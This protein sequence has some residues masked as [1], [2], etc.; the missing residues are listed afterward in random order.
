MSNVCYVFINVILWGIGV[1]Y[2]PMAWEGAQLEL[3]ASYFIFILEIP[4]PGKTV[5]ILGQFDLLFL[6][7]FLIV[8]TQTFQTWESTP[9]KKKSPQISIKMKFSPGILIYNS[10]AS[11]TGN[12][13][14][15]AGIESLPEPMLTRSMAWYGITG[16]LWGNQC[17]L[18]HHSSTLKVIHTCRNVTHWGQDKMADIFPSAFSNAFSW[19]NMQKLQF[20][21]H[22]SL[23]LWV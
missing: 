12:G 9:F 11:G 8:I 15:T 7:K 20:K 14:V 4:I 3:R 19:M 6:L 13:L 1:I 16:P 17:I 10:S 21:F 18:I 23:F 2:W 22:W 5:F